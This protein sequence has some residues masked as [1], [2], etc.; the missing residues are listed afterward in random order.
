MAL[1]DVFTN[2]VADAANKVEKA[3]I[4][5]I[6]NLITKA[7]PHGSVPVGELQHT[8]DQV[9]ATFENPPIHK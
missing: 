9:K 4:D 5:Q 2:L 3:V 8:L 6:T 7:G 1:K